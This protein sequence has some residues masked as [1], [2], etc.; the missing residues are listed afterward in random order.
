MT[1]FVEANGPSLLFIQYLVVCTIT[2]MVMKKTN[3]E[4][5]NIERDNSHNQIDLDEHI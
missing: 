2:T 5:Q 1:V 3:H 4:Y